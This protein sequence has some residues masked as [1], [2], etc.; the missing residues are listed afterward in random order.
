MVCPNCGTE[1]KSGYTLQ[2]GFGGS[3]RVVKKADT[4]VSDQIAL[5]VCPNCG[6]LEP[7]VDYESIK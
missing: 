4:P 3:V 6:K 7:F 2:L 1:M 5:L